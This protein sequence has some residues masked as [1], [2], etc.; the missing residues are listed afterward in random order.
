MAT[1]PRIRAAAATAAK[2]IKAETNIHNAR[3]EAIYRGFQQQVTAIQAEVN[4]DSLSSSSVDP[5]QSPPN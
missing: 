2:Q 4:A 3:L 5:I 1:D